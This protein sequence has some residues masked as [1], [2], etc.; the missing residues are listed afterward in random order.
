[1]FDKSFAPCTTIVKNNPLSAILAPREFYHPARYYYGSLL[2]L[3][4]VH[5]ARMPY[6]QHQRSVRCREGEQKTGQTSYTPK[7]IKPREPI[8]IESTSIFK[9][10]FDKFTSQGLPTFC[11]LYQADFKN[12]LLNNPYRCQMFCEITNYSHPNRRISFQNPLI[13]VGK[14]KFRSKFFS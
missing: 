7:R 3:L 2:L 5:Y 4:Y 11:T 14:S 8:K 12:I 9:K 10:L 6:A 13:F 1:M